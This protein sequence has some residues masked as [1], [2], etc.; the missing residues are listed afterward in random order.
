M[1]RLTLFPINPKQCEGY[2]NGARTNRAKCFTVRRAGGVPD[3]SHLNTTTLELT[4]LHIYDHIARAPI[5]MISRRSTSVIPEC[6]INWPHDNYIER[7]IDEQGVSCLR[8]PQRYPRRIQ[9][10]IYSP[11]LKASYF[12][13]HGF[14]FH[15][16]YTHQWTPES[17]RQATVY[18]RLAVPYRS[19][20]FTISQLTDRQPY[21]CVISWE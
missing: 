4:L 15:T 3:V 13:R 8:R 9:C 10:V 14:N 17:D 20:R 21:N 12:R 16:R 11:L 6:V 7:W 5:S 2:T 1:D 18:L 19:L